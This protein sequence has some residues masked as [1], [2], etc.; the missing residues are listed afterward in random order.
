MGRESPISLAIM[1]G[2]IKALVH[3]VAKAGD[4]IVQ[5]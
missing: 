3:C 5:G 1:T 2:T 4:V